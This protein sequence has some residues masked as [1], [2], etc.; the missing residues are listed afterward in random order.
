[1]EVINGIEFGSLL[2]LRVGGTFSLVA[3]CFRGSFML[4]VFL[5]LFMR[6]QFLWRG[7]VTV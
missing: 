4:G 2:V 7:F 5:L 1:M 6:A 3:L